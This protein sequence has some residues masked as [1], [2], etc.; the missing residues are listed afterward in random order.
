MNNKEKF[1]IFSEFGSHTIKD[2]PNHV[3]KYNAKTFFE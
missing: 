2:N 3:V 1:P